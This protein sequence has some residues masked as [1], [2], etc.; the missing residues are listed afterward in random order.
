[1]LRTSISQIVASE[2]PLNF[3]MSQLHFQSCRIQIRRILNERKD[4]QVSKILQQME[5]HNILLTRNTRFI[6]KHNHLMNASI[7]FGPM[8]MSSFPCI[9]YIINTYPIWLQNEENLIWKLIRNKM[10]SLNQHSKLRATWFKVSRTNLITSDL[11]ILI[12]L[13]YIMMYYY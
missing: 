5:F 3:Y 1:M 13:Q 7:T 8:L 12:V 4:Q 10:K 11:S 2:F 9:I 6:F